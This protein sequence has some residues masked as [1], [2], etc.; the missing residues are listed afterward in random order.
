MIFC[1]ILIFYVLLSLQTNDPIR[2]TLQYAISIGGATDTISSMAGALAGAL[3]GSHQINENILKH[4]E[5]SNEIANI[6]KK[7]YEISVT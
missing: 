5:G 4:C 1:V 6:G 7:I 3:H 2:K